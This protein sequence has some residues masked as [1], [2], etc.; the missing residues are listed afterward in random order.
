MIRTLLK[1]RPAKWAIAA[2]AMLAAVGT[3]AQT[4]NVVFSDD[5][6]DGTIDSTKWRSDD[7]PFESG[8]SDIQVYESNGA[9]EFSGT[10]IEQ[11][12][13]GVSLATVPTF[14]ASL[15]TNLVITV[16]RL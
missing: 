10:V 6:E 16:D 1:K 7:T 5:F 12:W 8:T 11:W 9:L 13:P 3:H 15:E 14:N 4:S 2:C